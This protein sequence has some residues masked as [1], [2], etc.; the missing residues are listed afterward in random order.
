MRERPLFHLHT[1]AW[2]VL[3]SP[4]VGCEAPLRQCCRC[5]EAESEE[6]EEIR[7]R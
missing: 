1:G 6:P 4:A 5:G 3:Q 7:K 2:A